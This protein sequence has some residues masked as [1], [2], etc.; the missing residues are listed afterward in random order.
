MLPAGD[1]WSVVIES[2]NN[3]KQKAF[4]IDS[5]GFTSL[6]IDEKKGGL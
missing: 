5:R 3:A 1:M 6:V 4:D 2:P